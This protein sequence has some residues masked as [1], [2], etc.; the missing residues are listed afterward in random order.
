[1]AAT[2]AEPDLGAAA[3]AAI[4]AWG[5]STCGAE[6]ASSDPGSAYAARVQAETEVCAQ[7]CGHPRRA[8]VRMVCKARQLKDASELRAG[9]QASASMPCSSM[10]A[11]TS[12]NPA[13]VL[14]LVIT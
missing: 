3:F 5:R 12:A 4:V 13:W 2:Q 11:T 14:R 8:G 10:N 1:M 9:A 7:S 6:L